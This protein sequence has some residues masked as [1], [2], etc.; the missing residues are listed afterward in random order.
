MK[1][2]FFLALFCSAANLLAAQNA[3]ATKPNIVLIYVD[4]LGLGN[5]Q[6]DWNGVISPG[7][8]EVGFQYSFL[9]PA[10][11]DRVPCVFVENGR[12]A[13]LDP[14][15]P[16]TVSYG[17]RI[18]TE[19]I[20]LE[21]PEMLKMQADTQHANTIINGISRIGYM[22]GG[23]TALWK[24][25]DFATVLLGKAK[26]FL[27][28]NKAR[29]FFLFFSLSDIHVPRAPAPMF[30]GKTTMGRRGDNI[31]QM[32]WVV[33]ELLKALYA[34]KLADNTLV[35]FSSDNGP[36]LD[37]GY[38]DEAVQL[39][40]NHKAAGP[41]RGGKYSA[42]EGGTRMPTIVWWPKKIRSGTSNALVSQVDLYASLAAL[43][44][45]TL[46]PNEAPDSENLLPAFLGR[47]AKG[48][49][50]L[51]EEAFTLALRHHDWKYVDPQRV[52]TPAWEKGKKIESG[53]KPFPQ[54]YRLSADVG[55]RINLAEQNPAKADE[56]KKQLAAIE[57]GATR[58]GYKAK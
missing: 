56:M 55:E 16:I 33:G 44:G 41:F 15:D 28:E 3:A 32:D 23:K 14:A 39:A 1:S 43:V 57:A 42:Y 58:V 38:A 27:A 7:A 52:P 48:R 35:V 22:S 47:S 19:P 10:T 12:V 8:K 50:W 37:D 40:G 13:N 25:E 54:L 29:P 53:L 21:H 46:A 17:R 36:V 51:L 20:G 4:D 30:R 24:D 5:G 9:I 2:I 31:V 11:Q 49:E 6:I 45:H 34:Q 26:R 18:G